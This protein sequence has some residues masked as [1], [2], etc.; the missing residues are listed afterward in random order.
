MTLEWE[1]GWQDVAPEV[2]VR[3]A[4]PALPDGVEASVRYR[5]IDSA[6]NAAWRHYVQGHLALHVLCRSIRAFVS[7][8]NGTPDT[9]RLSHGDYVNEKGLIARFAVAVGAVATLTSAF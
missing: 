6:L 4:I 8:N 7:K 2:L 9:D 3:R 5:E 1:S